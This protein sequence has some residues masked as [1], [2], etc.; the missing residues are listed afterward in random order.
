MLRLG[1]KIYNLVIDFHRKSVKWLCMTFKNIFIP[2]LNFHNFKKLG[3]KSKA[4]MA[5]LRHCEF[6]ERLIDKSR[7]YPG[8]KV[9]EVTEEY[10][11]KTCGGCGNLHSDLGN[12]DLYD[13]SKCGIQIERDYN[14]ARNIM[15]K[16]MSSLY[17]CVEA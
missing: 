6:L 5:S 8:C 12:K 1:E 2:R 9:V 16:Y 3:K 15:L 7:E 14:G 17:D 13:C 11:S 4:K 10:T